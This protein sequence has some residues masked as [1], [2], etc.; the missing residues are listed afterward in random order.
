MKRRL[1]VLLAMAAV[2]A[3][4]AVFVTVQGVSPTPRPDEKKLPEPRK[5][6]ETQPLYLSDAR[7]ETANTGWVALADDNLPKL[8]TSFQ[9][10]PISISGTSY[11]KGIGT[12]PLSE[13]TYR[14]DGRYGLFESM[15]GLDDAVP[16]GKGSV[17]F[18]VFL[19]D[20]LAFDSGIVRS[21]DQPLP[22]EVP[23]GDAGRLR[24][25]VEDAGDGSSLDYA[26]W[27]EA[28]LS[29]AAD[30]RT[31]GLAAEPGGQEARGEERAERQSEDWQAVR[32][33]S[34]QEA[35]EVSAA[36]Q[37]QVPAGDAR[38]TFDQ[39]SN[40]LVLADGKLAVTLGYG[41]ERNG[42][43]SVANLEAG[44]MAIIGSTP[45]L[46]L[47]DGQTINLSRDTGP[48]GLGYRSR[49]VQD[50]ALGLGTELSADFAVRGSDTVITPR[51][52]LF[53]SS[54]YLTYQLEVRGAAARGFSFFE[55]GAGRFV[56]GEDAGYL[57]DYSLIRRAEVHD[58]SILHREL[59]GLGKPVLIYDR[60]RSRGTLMAILDEVSSPSEFSIQVDGGKISAAVG[61]TYSVPDGAPAIAS[62]PR[63]LLHSSARG[64][65]REATASYRQA[66]AALHPAPPI[67]DWVK[68]QWGTWYAFG[69]SYDEKMVREQVDYIA[70]NL[71]DLGPW[72]VLLDAGWYVAEGKPGSGWDQ[73]DVEKFP[74]G[75]RAFVDYAHSRGVK[76]VLYL[77]APYLDDREREGNWL[78]LKGF[79][80]DHPDWL[81]KL[82]SDASG[83]SY[84]YDFGN[85]ELVEYMRGLIRGFFE[86]Y[87]V[88]GIKIDGLGQAEGE[89]LSVEE[90][91]VFGDVNKIRMF[92]MDIYR[93]IYEEA[94]RAKKDVYIESG[95]AVPA[96]ANQY[97]H[98]FRYGDEFP[99]IEHRY[100]AGGLLEHIDYAA[101]QKRVIGQRPNM[102]M[103]WGGPETQPMVRL[104][105][106]AALAM[107]T[108]M[109]MSVDLTR[110]SGRDL[111]A[112][113][114]VL[115]HYNA[116]EGDSYFVGVPQATSFATTVE[117]TT[118]LGVVN[119]SEGTTQQTVK[120]ADYGLA[121]GVEYLLYDVL[122]GSYSRVKGSF[123][124]SLPGP[125]F[126]PFLLRNTPGVIWTDS[127]IQIETRADSMRLV[128]KGPREIG[129][130][131]QIYAPRLASIWLDGKELKRSTTVRPGESY[132]YNATTGVVRLRYDHGREHVI[133][134]RY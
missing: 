38:A 78:G 21:G 124:V 66:M 1:L 31:A 98:S 42:L 58:D 87:D 63:L 110:L 29:P 11:G 90:R 111:A 59:V 9:N 20:D 102:G 10:N 34:E 55:P 44:T 95:W 64:G 114:S 97:A 84:V 89:Q 18:K 117:G 33:R 129:G 128:A 125:S 120:L 112:L 113:R 28:R 8:D 50:P 43:L 91:D 23:L 39:R 60:I 12:F 17:V 133:E 54:S 56:V 68:Y 13:I 47:E 7:W 6:A 82:Q 96:Y 101:L 121:D 41:G 14:L 79:V 134:V 73:E 67:P 106:E 119:R 88:D 52:T 80:E 30:S 48:A 100:P 5:P 127:S 51:L 3:T 26:V 40:L 132:S 123:Q 72:S 130:M 2:A 76:V 4:A 108:Q 86:K 75:L 77:S 109:T 99:S 65:L 105:Y 85:P 104:W 103:V 94:T 57:T 81:I 36:F 118:Y 131:A 24:L 16:Q 83:S 62:S 19:D 46:A 37:G 25:V 107:G 69:M 74:S 15:V 22:I 92:T 61:F 49:R 93:I 35:S 53:D 116:F 115:W 27:A 70:E 32:A 126:H 71:S 122:S 45:A